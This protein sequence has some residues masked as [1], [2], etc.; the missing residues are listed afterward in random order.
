MLG[1]Y[2]PKQA[3]VDA[4]PEIPEEPQQPAVEYAEGMMVRHA[5]FGDGKVVRVM[6]EESRIAVA[7]AEGEKVLSTKIAKLEIISE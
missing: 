2:R 7:F 6:P 4:M 1:F 5:K 3:Y